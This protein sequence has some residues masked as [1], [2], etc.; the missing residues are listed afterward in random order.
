MFTFFS[1][2]GFK[3]DMQSLGATLEWN[4]LTST[5]SR[6]THVFK[7]NSLVSSVNLHAFK[8]IIVV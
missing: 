6:V 2:Y 3:I 7:C 8:L 1:G 5:V 4:A